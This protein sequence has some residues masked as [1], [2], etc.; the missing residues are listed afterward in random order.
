M[1]ITIPLTAAV[2][3]AIPLAS[4]AQQGTAGTPACAIDAVRAAIARADAA[5]GGQVHL[6][7][8]HLESGR[9]IG[10]RAD[11]PVLMA[12]VVKLPLALRILRMAER[13]EI[14]LDRRIHVGPTEFGPGHSP[15]RE[16]LP[17]G[18][19]EVTVRDLVR[20]AV[21]ESDNTAADLL[22]RLGGGPAA[23]T[24]DLRA[25]GAASIRVDRSY[26][27][28]VAHNLGMGRV[29]VSWTLASFDSAAR[30]VPAARR[31]AAEA[32]FASDPANGATPADLRDLLRRLWRGE[33]L[34]AAGRDELLRIMTDSR[35]PDTRVVAGVPGASVAHKTG[36]WGAPE[37][38]FAV[39]DVALVTLPGDG[40]HVAIALM[41]K[42]PRVP[43][44]Q[45]DAAMAEVA[46]VAVP[47]TA[48]TEG[49]G[50][51]R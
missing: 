37:G 15:L 14:D 44:A 17:A 20:A 30:A 27:E 36:T 8:E 48:G 21:S 42:G 6:A 32:L 10:V 24:A 18:G 50:A 26:R 12:S 2:L 1:R 7:A 3:A 41:V 49:C 19:G 31:Q 34:G 9:R 23:V 35:N 45:V 40:G 4:H 13:G 29:R 38:H 25:M 22:L 11:G 51:R 5:T 16:R 39:N 47:L 46:R 43:L 33:I 28:M